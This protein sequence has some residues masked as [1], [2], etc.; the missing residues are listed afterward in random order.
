MRGGV[1]LRAKFAVL[2]ALLGFAAG[3]N[4][5]TVWWTLRHADRELARP[6]ASIEGVLGGLYRV[7][8]TLEEQSEA[9]GLT[10]SDGEVTHLGAE[11]LSG[12][13]TRAGFFNAC[14]RMAAE[15]DRLE[16]RSGDVVSAGVSTL[17]GLRERVADVRAA[18][19]ALLETPEPAARRRAGESVRALHELIERVEGRIIEDAGVSVGHGA[20]VQRA[21]VRVALIS[22]V[23]VALAGVLAVLVFKRWVLGPVGQL[24][25]GAARFAA[26]DLAYRV[27]Q[28]GRD[29]L[30][31]LAAEFNQMAGQI[32]ALHAER[33]EREKLAAI[34]EMTRRVV[35]NVRS[36]LS[37]IRAL[38]E[39]SR[40]EA[41]TDA[42][43]VREMQ[44]RIAATV[45]KLDGWLERLVRG[46]TTLEPRP[47]EV[48]VLPWLGRALEAH[49]AAAEGR[50][51]TLDARVVP[52]GLT[53]W[54][55][56][57]HAEQAV[58]AL[59]ANAVD[60]SPA[61]G[62]VRVR[63]VREE[64]PGRAGGVRVVVGDDGPGVP[65]GV[66]EAVFRAYFTTRAGGTGIGL[67]MVKRVA[68]AHAGWSRVAGGPG[69]LPGTDLGST[70]A[71]FELVLAGRAVDADG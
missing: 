47:Q 27:P 24:R 20:G 51:V 3:V 57:G 10:Q 22:M 55:D 69:R 15:V 52:D 67:A 43:G 26:G 16:T 70:G 65:E 28:A 50:A 54:F 61:G 4:A 56:P 21:V 59:V 45:D 30:G 48:V 7:K 35:H 38:A 36:P 53:G 40:A 25:A 18:G 5:L 44:E 66:R 49:R 13:D 9:L 62:V 14:E 64:V 11:P 2:L 12:A 32:E 8:R 37:G 29:E 17:R 19:R 31:V 42:A 39:M 60:F 58:Q 46:S 23:P 71:V 6:L 33:L 68:E 1:S 63:V 41:T 34:G